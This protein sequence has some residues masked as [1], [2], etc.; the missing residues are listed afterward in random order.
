MKTYF[1][2]KTLKLIYGNTKFHFLIGDLG[3]ENFFSDNSLKLTYGRVKFKKFFGK[4]GKI[5]EKRFFLKCIKIH[6]WQ[7]KISKKFGEEFLKTFFCDNALKL[8]YGKVKFQNILVEDQTF[9]SSSR[10]S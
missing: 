6:L 9:W 7:C 2:N 8:T 3:Y 5:D 1:P 10:R 4:L